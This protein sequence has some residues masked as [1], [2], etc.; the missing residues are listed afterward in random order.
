MARDNS[1][2]F[3][4]LAAVLA[5]LGGTTPASAVTLAGLGIDNLYVVGAP[6]AVDRTLAGAQ[7]RVCAP[8]VE[9]LPENLTHYRPPVDE[10][11]RGLSI[12]FCETALVEPTALDAVL[13]E[14]ETMGVGLEARRISDGAIYRK[15]SRPPPALL[16]PPPADPLQP[17]YGALVAGDPAAAAAV[18]GSGVEAAPAIQVAQ[19]AKPT[20][21]ATSSDGDFFK[22]IREIFEPAASTPAPGT[23]TPGASDP[24]GAESSSQTPER[25]ALDEPTEILYGD[26]ARYVGEI[27]GDRP[28]GQGEL[29]YADGSRYIGAFR[30]GL[31]EGP[32][33]LT[34]ADGLAY[35][36]GFTHDAVDGAGRLTWPDGASYQGD[37]VL[38]ERTG[39]GVY[40]WPSGSRYEGRFDNGV[41]VGLG[42]FV[43][44]DGDRYEGQFANGRGMGRGVLTSPNGER[45]EG[46]VLDGA[47]HGQGVYT[48]PDGRTRSGRWVAGEAVGK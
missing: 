37:F 33:R 14:A 25:P 3:G 5:T 6:V 41:I 24:G 10:I 23:R 12:D 9:R 34:L 17:A 18:L 2:I 15:G 7:A 32:G 43:A 39:D 45:Y 40:V 30:D 21:E 38:G 35:E 27:S 26:G 11:A 48:W 47:P 31:R 22:M 4:S 1:V 42:V 20:A 8:T 36:G 44:S 19:A 46:E 16:A 13:A 28:N 29:T